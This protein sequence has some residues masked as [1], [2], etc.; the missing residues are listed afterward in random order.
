M[1]IGQGQIDLSDEGLDAMTEE[2]QPTEAPQEE[3]QETTEETEVVEPVED[4]TEVVEP[5]T[6]EVVEP[7]PQGQADDQ[8]RELRKWATQLSMENAELRKQLMPKPEP[9]KPMDKDALLQKLVEN[10]EAT[11]A[12][13]MGRQL[14][15]KIKPLSAKL[16][17]AE[18]KAEMTELASKL[19][20]I[21]PELQKSYPNLSDN[22]QKTALI[23]KAAEIGARLGS[24][25]A[26]QKDPDS[27]LKLAA[28]EMYGLPKQTDPAILQS[29]REKA[30]AEALAELKNKEA[31]KKGSLSAQTQN[32]KNNETSLSPEE[33]IVNEIMNS[34]TGR[35]L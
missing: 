9:E 33:Q 12:E 13:L 1:T 30:K 14:E 23:N 26:L 16:E 5:E 28:V 29:E 24:A 4:P 21:F 11:L 18:R 31:A 10:P 2:R 19:Q 3:T 32:N 20:T 15:E 34:R 6:P 17:E 8:M 7:A 25:T 22:L 27:I 35:Y